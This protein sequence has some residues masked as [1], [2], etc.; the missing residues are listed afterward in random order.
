MNYQ[1]Y[2]IL[3]LF[4]SIYEE[5]KGTLLSSESSILFN[6]C[7]ESVPDVIFIDKTE[8]PIPVSSKL[9]YQ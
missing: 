5:V 3:A 9:E 4:A 7:N 6:K 8:Y 1:L 2:L